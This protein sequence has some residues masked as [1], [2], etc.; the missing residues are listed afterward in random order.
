MIPFTLAAF[1][2]FGDKHLVPW[3]ISHPLTIVEAAAAYF[4]VGIVWGFA[5]WFFYV[6]KARDRYAALRE[7]FF[8]GQPKTVTGPERTTITDNNRDAFKTFLNRNYSIKAGEPPKASQNKGRIIFW[9]SYWPSSALWTLINDPITRL[10]QFTYRKLGTVFE[11]ISKAM[12]S[13]YQTDLN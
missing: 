9:M 7:E 11:N 1:V 12:F 8:E 6:L 10:Y 13:K 5:K 3:V 4:V 2:A